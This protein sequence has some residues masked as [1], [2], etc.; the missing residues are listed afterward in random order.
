MYG[1]TGFY[2]GLR[3]ATRR[4]IMWCARAAAA[5]LQALP[6]PALH[7]RMRASQELLRMTS[8]GTVI[9]GDSR[10]R[11]CTNRSRQQRIGSHSPTRVGVCMHA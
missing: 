1:A 6:M 3:H 9:G 8:I 2:A 7:A 4:E 11:W 10:E 5:N